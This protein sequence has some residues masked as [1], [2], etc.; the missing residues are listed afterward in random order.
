MVSAESVS[1]EVITIFC[2]SVV[3]DVCSIVVASLSATDSV[4]NVWG[5]V[6]ESASFV[7][8][9]V[10]VVAVE[11]IA[12]NATNQRRSHTFDVTPRCKK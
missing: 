2:I 3:R 12:C 4:V 11:V 7:G 8:V 10:V 1:V 5:I 9:N 6:V